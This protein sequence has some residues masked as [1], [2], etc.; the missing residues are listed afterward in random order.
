[1]KGISYNKKEYNLFDAFDLVTIEW[2]KEVQGVDASKYGGRGLIGDWV[3]NKKPTHKIQKYILH[4]LHGENKNKIKG[5]ILFYS[6]YKNELKI[7]KRTADKSWSS[8]FIP[9]I[10]DFLNPANAPKYLG[11]FT[12]TGGE[13]VITKDL[14]P[15]Y[16]VTLVW[17]IACFLKGLPQTEVENKTLYE[18]LAIY[19]ESHE[20]DLR[21]LN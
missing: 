17:E 2:I 20:I 4:V 6:D 13:G 9:L 19:I 14:N 12:E 1:M 3:F 16:G 7:L 15:L 10:R 11:T 8:Q 18:L 21:I 5:Y